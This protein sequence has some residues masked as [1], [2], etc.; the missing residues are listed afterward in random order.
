M[1]VVLLLLLCVFIMIIINFYEPF[2]TGFIP[3]LSMEKRRHRMAILELVSRLPRTD[4]LESFCHRPP[5]G[6]GRARSSAFSYNVLPLDRSESALV[7]VTTRIH[8]SGKRCALLSLRTPVGNA[9]VSSA[10]C[11][12]AVCRAAGVARSGGREPTTSW[13]AVAARPAGVDGGFLRVPLPVPAHAPSPPRQASRL[14]CS[15]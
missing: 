2:C 6:R 9:L 14:G 10:V 5:P 8:L 15:V 3:S 1:L 12:L 11:D 13:A 7:E 4:G